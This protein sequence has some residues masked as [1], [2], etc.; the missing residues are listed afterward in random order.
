MTIDSVQQLQQVKA[1]VAVVPVSQIS[2]NCT[3]I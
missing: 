3:L 2:T 1:A